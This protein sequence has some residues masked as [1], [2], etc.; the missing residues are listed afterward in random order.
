MEID[1]IVFEEIVKSI[2]SLIILIVKIVMDT[3]CTYLK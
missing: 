1:N 2:Y 3:S